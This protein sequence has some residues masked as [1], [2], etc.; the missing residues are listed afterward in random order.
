MNKDTEL[1]QF[2]K[3]TNMLIFCIES[4]FHKINEEFYEEVMLTSEC[5]DSSALDLELQ[6]IY[7]ARRF[8]NENK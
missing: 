1:N 7:S 4:I 5:V 8:S 6:K 2:E 3:G